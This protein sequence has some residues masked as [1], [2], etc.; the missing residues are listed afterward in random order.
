MV[1]SWT[2]VQIHTT[3]EALE[4]ISHILYE[5]GAQGLVVEELSGQSIDHQTKNSSTQQ[6]IKV[7]FPKNK[8]FSQKIT[9]IEKSIQQLK[10]YDI[11]IGNYSIHLSDVKAEDWETSWQKYY[12]SVQ[13]SDQLK[14]VPIWEKDENLQEKNKKIIYLDPGMAFGTGTHPTTKLSLLALE[15]YLHPEDTVID[16]GCGS[17][18]LSIASCLLGAK[19]V[20]A[21]DIDPLAVRSAKINRSLN[22]LEDCM[23]V[24]Q[25]DLL[26]NIP[27]QANVIVA[28]I[29]MNVI[30]PLVDQAWHCL[31]ENGIFIATGILN[32]QQEKVISA[33]EQRGFHMIE[34]KTSDP[35]VCLIAKK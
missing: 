14:I 6:I 33:L 20:L 31:R 34:A 18:V 2:E 35:W 21:L 22:Y 29:L 3:K 13:I 19:S 16:V 12:H 4:P 15:D 11:N 27:L 26:K 30:L 5:E 7:Y 9:T 25:N 28:N 32:E 10:T 24:K 23:T 8:G 17:G 1:M